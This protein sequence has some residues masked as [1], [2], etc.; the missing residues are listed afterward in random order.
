MS[1]KKAYSLLK[2]P[3]TY[4]GIAGVILSAF[5]LDFMSPEQVGGILAALAAM[6]VP[7]HKS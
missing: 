6:F 3:S 5:G 4:G 2:E 7:E 1:K